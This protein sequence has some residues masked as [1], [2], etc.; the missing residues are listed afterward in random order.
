MTGVAFMMEPGEPMLPASAPLPV[1]GAH[2][3]SLRPAI[4]AIVVGAGPN[5]LAAAITLQGAGRRVLL[6][7]AAPTV[8]GGLRSAEL[9]L[10]GFVH[11]VCS[12]VHPLGRSSPF[13]RQLPLARHGLRWIEP[14]I[15]LAHPFDDAETAFVHR[16]IGETAAALGVDA[17]AYSRLL[18]SVAGSWRLIV[19]DLAG[20]FRIPRNPLTALR[21]ARFG[22]SALQPATLLARRFRTPQARALLAGCAAHS[23]LRLTEPL[24]G[25]FGL[26][27]LGGAHA[28]G[29]PIAEG[30][31][32]RLADALAVHFLELG[33][34]IETDRYVTTLDDLP[35]HRALLLDLT[36][37]QVLRLAGNRFRRRRFGG[38]YTRQLRRFRRGTGVFK[39]DIALDG[40]LPWRDE[41]IL[42]AG[43]V[44][45]GGTLEEIAASED[46][47]RRG[48]VP[49]R[50]FVLLSQPSL[51]DSTRA[52]AGKHTVWAY[53]HVPNGS[54]VDMTQVIL[55]QIERFAPGARDRVLAIASR[56]P[57][58]LEDDNPNIVGGD[59][60]GGLQ[61]LRQFWT[62]P[63]IRRDPYSTPDPGVF[64]CSSATP[65]GGGAH[66][67]CGWRAARS[68]LRS[69]LR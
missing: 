21:A 18:G 23:M 36:P 48:R 24:S 43:T 20:P 6:L 68:A 56:G 65:P 66:G 55:R 45:L 34:E 30:G 60:L 51:F 44:H 14:G 2:P 15:E 35:P 59:I 12:A 50:P 61:D 42:E 25:G 22:L 1:G 49:D 41:R 28:V 54:R 38:I 46:A 40:P 52:P 69:A 58:E 32:Q 62:R 57:A 29:W 63:A 11:D 16:D 39:L 67:I 26:T 53:C 13:F 5:G 8:G 33:G 47:V 17:R 7:E 27:L 10:P 9:T 31:S 3:A 37:P 4:D 64:I 19:G